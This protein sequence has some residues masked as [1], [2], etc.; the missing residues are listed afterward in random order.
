MVEAV[1]LLEGGANVLDTVEM[2]VRSAG[3]MDSVL[4]ER[5]RHEIQG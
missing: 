5:E 2:K 3:A 4:K 1:E